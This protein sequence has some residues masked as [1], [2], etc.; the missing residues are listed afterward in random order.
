M[1]RLVI[2]SALLF[3]SCDG[4]PFKASSDVARGDPPPGMGRF[5]IRIEN[6]AP[7]CPDGGT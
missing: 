5:V 3:A 7:P 6:V 1:R 4:A 2:I